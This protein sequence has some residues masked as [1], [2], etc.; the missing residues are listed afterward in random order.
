M[1]YRYSKNF[2]S[3][4]PLMS[5]SELKNAPWNE[6][7]VPCIERDC[8]VTETISRRIT[9]STTDYSFED[10]WN[11]EFGKCMVTDT[12]E[13]DWNEE[14]S[15]QEYTALELIARLKSYVEEDIKNTQPNT[16]KVRKLRRL[17]HACNGWE[18]VEIEVEELNVK[19]Q[20]E[21]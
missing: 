8:E 11:D 16:D 10:D 4:Y 6:V 5:Q 9:L 7:N 15:N 14:Y 3:N 2:N 18:Q 12:S 17:L 19:N 20:I 13:T 1:S 21:R